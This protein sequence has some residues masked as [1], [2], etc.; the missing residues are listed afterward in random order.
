MIY[1]QIIGK[2]KGTYREVIG[3]F[4]DASPIDSP[5]RIGS[6]AISRSAYYLKKEL[7]SKL[8]YN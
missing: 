4:T 5:F 3:N 7:A 8:F 6:V 2:L 1:L